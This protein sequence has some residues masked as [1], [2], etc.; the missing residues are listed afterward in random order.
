M[1]PFDHRHNPG[2]FWKVALWVKLLK[3]LLK[4]SYRRS[5]KVKVEKIIYNIFIE[6]HCLKF[7]SNN[8]P[9]STTETHSIILH[10]IFFRFFPFFP[11]NL[12]ANSYPSYLFQSPIL[13]PIHRPVTRRPRRSRILEIDASSPSRIV[14]SFTLN[15]DS[16]TTVYSYPTGPAESSPLPWSCEPIMP[17]HLDP[18]KLSLWQGRDSKPWPSVCSNRE[19]KLQLHRFLS[20]LSPLHH[21][22][23]ILLSMLFI[24]EK[25]RLAPYL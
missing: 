13:L 14:S 6:V 12:V 9:P 5:N 22:G 10:A 17:L 24:I 16:E 7:L 15:R 4:Q 3:I 20:C 18:V 25:P 8:Q 11:P 1:N 21:H 23:S 19:L 2:L